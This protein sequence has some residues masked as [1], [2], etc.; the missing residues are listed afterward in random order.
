MR[1]SAPRAKRE[2]PARPGFDRLF[3]PR[4]GPRALG[5]N[6]LHR[7]GRK[8]PG[9]TPRHR[10]TAAR[11]PQG[12]CLVLYPGRVRRRATR[13]AVVDISPGR[14]GGPSMAR[15]LRLYPAPGAAYPDLAAGIYR[16][17]S[18][19]PLSLPTQDPLQIAQPLLC[20]RSRC[21]FRTPC[22]VADPA[23]ASRK[24]APE[25]LR[26]QSNREGG[27]V[28]RP[29]AGTLRPSAGSHR[30]QSPAAARW[31]GRARSSGAGDRC[32]FPACASSRLRCSPR[33]RATTRR[34]RPRPRSRG[35]ET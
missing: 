4:S 30:F 31:R 14:G 32:G 7:M 12:S 8:R 2:N 24:K 9:K 33:P 23:K 25:Q 15:R 26:G 28:T 29:P 1:A 35:R 6:G 17:G 22:T 21:G 20:S 27:G 10:R 34:G 13:G 16:G 5:L 11:R 19:L 18:G 3:R